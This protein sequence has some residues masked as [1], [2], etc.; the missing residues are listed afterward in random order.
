LFC[1]IFQNGQTK[2]LPAAST[3]RM[4]QS[5]MSNSST[6]G[7]PTKN[8]AAMTCDHV[9]VTDANFTFVAIDGEGKPRPIPPA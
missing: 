4:R 6:S 1:V 8:T 2:A 7:V 5:R 9:K 3:P